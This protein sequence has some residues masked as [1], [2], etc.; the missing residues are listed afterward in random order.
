MRNLAHLNPYQL[1]QHLINE[2]IL[3]QPGSTQKL[4][5]DHSKDKRDIDVIKENHQFLWD[6]NEQVNATWEQQLARKYYEK[7]FKEY[8][9]SDLQRYKENKVI[10]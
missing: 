6:D 9:I 10:P 5:R 1:H 3:N 2:Y 4:G 8:T 7:L